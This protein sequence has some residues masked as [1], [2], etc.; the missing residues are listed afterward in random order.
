[1]VMV[2]LLLVAM[3]ARS[4]GRLPLAQVHIHLRT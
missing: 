1:M 2:S 4:N 3:D